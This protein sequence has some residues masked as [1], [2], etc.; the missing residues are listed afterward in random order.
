[1]KREPRFTKKIARSVAMLLIV[2]H[3]TEA[4]GLS[5]MSSAFAQ[6]L[7][8]TVPGPSSSNAGS[9][10]ELVNV[11]VED[12]CANATDTDADEQCNEKKLALATAKVQIVEGAVYTAAGIACTIACTPTPAATALPACKAL[13]YIALGVDV[14]GGVAVIALGKAIANKIDVAGLPMMGMSVAGSALAASQG[15][16][17]T[18]DAKG[19]EKQEVSCPMMPIT[20]LLQAGLRGMNAGLSFK[21]AAD[22]SNRARMIRSNN[23]LTMATGTPPLRASNTAG[24]DNSMPD[25]VNPDSPVLRDVPKPERAKVTREAMSANSATAQIRETVP[26]IFEEATG[27]PFDTVKVAMLNGASPFQVAAAFAGEQGAGLGALYGKID[28][29][30]EEII[31]DL[32]GD[33]EAQAAGSKIASNSFE[34]AEASG[35]GPA[36]DAGPSMP[37][38]SALLGNLM[39]G[40]QKKEQGPPGAKAVNF[41]TALPPKANAE[42]FHDKDRSIFDIVGARYFHVQT[43]F[44]AG[45]NIGAQQQASVSNNVPSNIY[46]RK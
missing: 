27:K 40:G 38:M 39:P 12:P 1:M 2:A 33:L 37:D 34:A 14:A 9:S 16:K 26:K 13:S 24:G 45:E 32:K 8:S 11:G 29:N 3:A 46:L 43:K 30:K 17:T 31:K 25:G 15:F 5:V 18:T 28:A 6:Q 22:A 10:G 23:H 42:G 21:K 7:K 36:N 4:V 41:G 35:R 44:L 20:L 19:K